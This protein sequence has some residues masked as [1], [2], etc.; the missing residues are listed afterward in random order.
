MIGD[1]LDDRPGRA[2]RQARRAGLRG[3]LRVGDGQAAG[4]GLRGAA[5][6]GGA[7]GDVG[8]VPAGVVVGEQRAHPV[9]GGAGGLQVARRAGDRVARVIAAGD[10][11]AVAVDAVAR[12][13]VRQ[14]LH[15]AAGAGAVL[16]RRD[17]GRLQAAVVGLDRPDGGQPAPAVPAELV[18]GGGLLIELQVVARNVGQRFG[19]RRVQRP[20]APLAALRGLDVG[21]EQHDPQHDAEQGRHGGGARHPQHACRRRAQDSA[22][23]SQRSPAGRTARIIE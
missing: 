11:V 5:I 3:A 23:T 13:R 16:A 17:A 14:E 9:T 19:R 12:P 15:R 6:G 21:A 20:A 10:P 8:A 1:G 22:T 4:V 7:R 2:G 18:V